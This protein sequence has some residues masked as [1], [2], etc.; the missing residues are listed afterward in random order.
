MICAAVKVWCI[1]KILGSTGGAGETQIYAA[2]MLY[3][4]LLSMFVNS[5]AYPILGVI[6]GEKDYR[7]IRMF[8]LPADLAASGAAAAWIYVKYKCANS[9]GKLSDFYL[10]ETNGS[11]LLYDVSLKA[12][13]S[14]AAKLSQESISLQRMRKPITA[15]IEL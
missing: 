10:I 14:D 6:Y 8:R 3:L 5:S 4:S 11:E 1:Y 12:T 13:E 7:S 2:C 15:V 9:Y